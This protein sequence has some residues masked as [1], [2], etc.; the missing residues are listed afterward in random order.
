MN[1]PII[2]ILSSEKL[3]SENFVKWKSNM[4]IAQI[5]E[6]YKFVLIKEC[7]PRPATNAPHPIREVYD[8]WIQANNK[9]RCYMLAVMSDVLRMKCEKIE[10]AYEIMESLQAMFGQPSNHLRHDAFKTTM[11]T[12]M[13]VGTL[14]REHILKM[15][16]WL[17]EIEIYGAVIDERS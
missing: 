2:T 8:H 7:P 10:A 15:I 14:V 1:N 16:N 11:N 13:K 3:N 12:K 5:C 4:N 6:N 9:A 17:N